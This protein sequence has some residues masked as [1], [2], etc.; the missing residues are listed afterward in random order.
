MKTSTPMGVLDM[1][2]LD[3]FFCLCVLSLSLLLAGIDQ[4]WVDIDEMVGMGSNLYAGCN[5]L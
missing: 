1:V 2:L 4:H 3:T 5:A